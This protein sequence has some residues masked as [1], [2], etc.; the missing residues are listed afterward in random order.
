MKLLGG[1]IDVNEEVGN[2]RVGAFEVK[3]GLKESVRSSGSENVR[4][5]NVS[6]IKVPFNTAHLEVN[7]SPDSVLRWKCKGAGPS[8]PQA[9]V[10]AGV[11]TL[12][13]DNLN[14]AK[15]SISLPLGASSE[16]H[17]VNGNMHVESPSNRMN[18]AITNGRVNIKP[19]SSRVYDFE[20][21]VKNGLQDFFPRNT[22]KDAVKVK[23]N[24]VNG[25]VK[26]E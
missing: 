23:V 22:A 19:D 13:L 15:C 9:E 21:N 14:L 1:L 12:N 7:T 3:G 16:F 8:A 17:G 25:M 26:K 6:V 24:I 4:D 20:V 11:L 2:L 5:K 18:I 10:A